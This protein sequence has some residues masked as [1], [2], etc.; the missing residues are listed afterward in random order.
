MPSN[1]LLAAEIETTFAL[2][3][4]QFYRD[5]QLSPDNELLFQA[6]AEF[7]SDEGF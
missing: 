3:N 2:T 6:L 7:R 5:F 4:N 1:A